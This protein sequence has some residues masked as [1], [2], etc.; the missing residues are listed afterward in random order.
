MEYL[1]P[2]SYP[3]WKYA[4]IRLWL[5]PPP[6]KDHIFTCMLLTYMAWDEGFLQCL[7]FPS[8]EWGV[9]LNLRGNQ[10]PLQELE[11]PLGIISCYWF[12]RTMHGVEKISLSFFLVFFM[13]N[14]SIVRIHH[15]HVTTLVGWPEKLVTTNGRWGWEKKGRSTI[16]TDQS[17]SDS[18]RQ[19]ESIFDLLLHLRGALLLSC[20]VHGHGCGWWNKYL[21][22]WEEDER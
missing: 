15:T 7:S 14:N 4:S 1:C 10:S 8:V 11:D 3:W 16:N 6:Q 12:S 2:F 13:A 5:V 21:E 19:L 17:R 9:L 20:V 18:V 22:E